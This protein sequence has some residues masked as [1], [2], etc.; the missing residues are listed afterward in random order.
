MENG[1]S[2]DLVQRIWREIWNQGLLD[3]VDDV[4]ADEYVGHI[5]AMPEPVRG[6]RGFKELIAAYRTAY[7]DVH[8]TVDDVIAS[9]DRV[10]VRWTSRGTNTGSFMGMKP[11]G[12]NVEVAG[13][14]IFRIEGGKVAEEWEGFDTLAMMRQLGAFEPAATGA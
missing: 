7:P 1:S 11:T 6:T 2:V 3:V 12:R 10:V 13:I 8:L 5:P 14:S 9:G 4:L